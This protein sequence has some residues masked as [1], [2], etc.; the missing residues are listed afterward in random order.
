MCWPWNGTG[1]AAPRGIA[2]SQQAVT[3]LEQ[4]AERSRLGM[5]HF[6]LGLNCLLLGDCE[7]ALEAEAQAD[8]VGKEIGDPHLQTFAAWTTGW[9]QAT[10]G[11]WEASIAASSTRPRV[12]PRSAQHRLCLGVS[13]L[14]L[15]GERRP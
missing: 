6:V 7:R 15:P 4:C 10:R 1:L 2:Y 9:A 12:S 13:G 3:L 8:A 5:A 11:E 14:C